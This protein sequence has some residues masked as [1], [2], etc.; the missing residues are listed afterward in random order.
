MINFDYSDFNVDNYS[1]FSS[2]EIVVGKNVNK[3]NL[4]ASFILQ[5][6]APMLGSKVQLAPPTVNICGKA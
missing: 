5:F 1:F 3:I 4:F 2:Y 6:T